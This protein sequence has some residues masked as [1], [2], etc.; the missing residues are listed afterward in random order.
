M[1]AALLV[2]AGCGRLGFAELGDARATDGAAD[3]THD[4]AADA[5]SDGASD[6][7]A[8]C[9]ALF[10]DDFEGPDFDPRW[11]LDTFHG[12]LSLDTTHAHGG[13]QSVHSHIDAIV[14][15]TTNARA[16][17]LTYEGLPVTGTIYVRMWLYRAGTQPTGFF[18]QTINLADDPGSGMSMGAKDKFMANN[19]YTPPTQYTQ[20]GS[21]IEPLDGW[22]C[23]MFAMPSGIAGTSRV[24]VDGNEL[25]DIAQSVN[26]A[27]PPPTHMYLGTEWVGTPQTQAATDAWIDDVAVDTAPLACN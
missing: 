12:T 8:L 26:A 4:A 13:V 24:Y 11:T 16:T 2:L 7:A 27:Q 18:D 23:V 1:R 5:A 20:S 3:A 9:G 21:D 22:T 10:C 15:A 14:N 19:D 17:L 25:T 6:G